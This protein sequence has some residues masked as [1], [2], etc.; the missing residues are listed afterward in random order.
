MG[1]F[2]STGASMALFSV[3]ATK[4]VRFSRGNL[5]FSTT[6]THEVADGT[7][8]GTWRL[9]PNQYDYIGADNANIASD[10][11]GW[12][13][14]FGWGTSGWNS[15]PGIHTQYQPWST[16]TDSNTAYSF[17]CPLGSYETSLVGDCAWADWGVYNAIS[18]GGNQPGQWRTLTA[19]EWMYLMC[20]RE[21]GNYGS[22]GRDR[23]WAAASVAGSHGLVLLPDEWQ[24]PDGITFNPGNYNSYATNVY[25]PE[26]WEAM[27]GAGAV[28]LPAAGF[29]VGTRVYTEEVNFSG[30]YWSAHKGGDA[31]AYSMIFSER[32][33]TNGIA[34]R[35]EGRSV[36][37][38]KDAE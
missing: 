14:L 26:Q 25:S 29:R 15:A 11:D 13:D 18:N 3:S 10:Y 38:V 35:Y 28:F 23:K 2:D 5:Q 36:R 19:A 33:M 24:A 22:A 27:E 8:A 9:A 4:K 16:G 20:D 32:H 6:G 34:L 17:Y 30:D 12:I 31:Y 1:G 37:L 7:A 21:Q